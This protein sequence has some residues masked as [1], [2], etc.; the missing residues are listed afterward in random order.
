[1]ENASKALIIA[2][3]ILLSILLISLGIMIFNQAQSAING[4]G[5]TDA[6][7]SAFNQKFTKYNG[8]QKGSEIRALVQEVMSNNNGAEASDETKVTINVSNGDVASEG[9]AD[10]VSLGIDDNAQPN[11]GSLS[12]TKT[13]NVTFKYKNGRVVVID[14]N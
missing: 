10:I 6:Q 12:N 9:K 11:F 7:L 4:S 2:G 8:K 1:M 13:Y 14:V 5:M 3:A